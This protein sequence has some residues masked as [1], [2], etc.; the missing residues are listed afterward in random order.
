MWQ[1]RAEIGD[2]FVVYLDRIAFRKL[3]KYS[4]IYETCISA[5][6]DESSAIQCFEHGDAFKIYAE[7]IFDFYTSLPHNI[8]FRV[9][10]DVTNMCYQFP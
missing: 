3:I 8:V 7:K 4:H 9:R 5:T 1:S 2:F 10:C 6:L